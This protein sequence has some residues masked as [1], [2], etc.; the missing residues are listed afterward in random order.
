MYLLLCFVFKSYPA[1]ML[2]PT[3]VGLKPKEAGADMIKF[4]RQHYIHASGKSASNK[5]INYCQIFNYF[6]FSEVTRMI[7]YF[8]KCRTLSYGYI[9]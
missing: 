5:S 2:K 1:N 7:N 8:G 4:V 6:N 9:I 3:P